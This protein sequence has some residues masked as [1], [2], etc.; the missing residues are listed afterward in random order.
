MLLSDIKY[1][2][3]KLPFWDLKQLSQFKYG[4]WKNDSY[5][6]TKDTQTGPLKIALII[7]ISKK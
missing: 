3:K 5:L 6:G 4:I 2:K 1:L 7:V